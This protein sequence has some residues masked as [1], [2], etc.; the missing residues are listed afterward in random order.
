MSK[1]CV[2]LLAIHVDTNK[3]STEIISALILEYQQA[4][5]ANKTNPLSITQVIRSSNMSNN[6]R[7]KALHHEHALLDEAYANKEI[8]RHSS[9]VLRRQISAMQL[10]IADEI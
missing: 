7:L 2:V 1:S 3:W 5:T 4:L 10:D 8:D 6:I 9:N